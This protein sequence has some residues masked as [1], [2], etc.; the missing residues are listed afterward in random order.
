MDLEG[1]RSMGVKNG[2]QLY[3]DSTQEKS[4]CWTWGASDGGK[5]L[6]VTDAGTN[7]VTGKEL[8]RDAEERGRSEKSPIAKSSK[9]VLRVAC[10]Y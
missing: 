6:K 5:E 9:K 8:L 3:R 2:Y 4:R 1:S 7:G 10:T